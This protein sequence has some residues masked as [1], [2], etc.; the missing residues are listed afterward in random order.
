MGM[1]K[2]KRLSGEDARVEHDKET[3]EVYRL[4]AAFTVDQLRGLL[5][6]RG[7]PFAS[8]YTRKEVLV[9]MA[10]DSS[11]KEMR[12]LARFQIETKWHRNEV[13]WHSH[14]LVTGLT[15]RQTC[16]AAAEEIDHLLGRL[17]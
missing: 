2:S 1:T 17:A 14:S 13:R 6:A 16:K 9:S 12:Y 4:Y 10:R 8:G 15:I 7:I 11:P 3:T 5:T